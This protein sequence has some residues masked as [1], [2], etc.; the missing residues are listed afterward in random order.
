MG[1]E[2]ENPNGSLGRR[3]IHQGQRP[4]AARTG[5][6]QT[7]NRHDSP[8]PKTPLTRGARPHNSPPVA[9]L[10][11]F[12]PSRVGT[13]QMHHEAAS[14]HADCVVLVAVETVTRVDEVALAVALRQP[15]AIHW[16]RI[17]GVAVGVDDH[18]VVLHR[19]YAPVGTTRSLYRATAGWVA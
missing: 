15:L 13:R 6:T 17:D 9:S 12:G 8:K 3:T 7:C 1:I 5:R 16:L 19:A 11:T 4:L 14:A 10:R 2:R 18:H